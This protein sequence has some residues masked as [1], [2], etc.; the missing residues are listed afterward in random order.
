MLSTMLNIKNAEAHRLAHELADLT[1]ESLT[2]AV[3]TSLRERLER[4]RAE[5]P[6]RASSEELMAMAK[7]IAAHMKPLEVGEDPT[8]FLYDD[9]GLPA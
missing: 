7:E 8:A 5:K 1:G 3:I 6:K 9:D 2:G 4:A